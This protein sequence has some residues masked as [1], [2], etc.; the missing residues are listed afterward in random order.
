MHADPLF[1]SLVTDAMFEKMTHTLCEDYCSARDYAEPNVQAE[2]TEDEQLICM[3]L[4]AW[5]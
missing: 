1:T 5:A 2:I 3:W 4:C